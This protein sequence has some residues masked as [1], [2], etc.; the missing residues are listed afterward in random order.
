MTDKTHYRKVFKSDHLGCADLEDYQEMGHNQVFTITEVR[1]ELG[2]KIAGN[3]C[4]KNIAYFN[5]LNGKKVKPLALNA[6]NSKILKE[7]ANGSPFVEDWAGIT[8]QLYID[9][10][11]KL[12]NEIVG[13][14]RISPTPVQITRE[15]IKPESAKRWELAKAAYKRDGN[16]DKVL[17]KADI[18]DENKTKLIAECA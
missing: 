17:A 15:I 4:D 12:M 9:P 2:V 11:V 18:S 1:Q 10:N 7:F 14:V 3:K 16:L 8:V 5:D 13:G 6:G